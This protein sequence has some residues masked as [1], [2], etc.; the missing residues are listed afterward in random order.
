MQI[1]PDTKNWTWVLDRPCPDC[2][3]DGP[4]FDVNASGTMLRDLGRR[5]QVVLRRDGVGVRPRPDKWSALEYGCHVRDVFRIFD[6][7]LSLMLSQDDPSFENWDQDQTAVDDDY[8]HQ[9]AGQVAAEL[10]AA[11]EALAARFDSVSAGQWPRRGLRSDGSAFTVATLS[12][13]LMHDPVHHLWDVGA[14]VPFTRR[15]ISS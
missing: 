10:D 11:A 2:G 4:A 14:D 12:R 7:R 3:Y 9:V 13:Y 5:W 6:Q 15:P 1:V 8:A